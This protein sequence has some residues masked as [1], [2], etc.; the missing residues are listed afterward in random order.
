[1]KI[2]MEEI[3]NQIDKAINRITTE[4]I[5]SRNVDIYITKDGEE[6]VVVVDDNFPKDI[7]RE[8]LNIFWS[9][10]NRKNN[11]LNLEFFDF[12]K[13]ILDDFEERDGRPIEILETSE[14][15]AL[16]DAILKSESIDGIQNRVNEVFAAQPKR[17][18]A[19][20]KYFKYLNKYYYNEEIPEFKES[21]KDDINE[22]LEE[23]RILDDNLVL[24]ERYEFNRLL[25]NKFKKQQQVIASLQSDNME[26]TIKQGAFVM[27][28]PI[29]GV[30]ELNDGDVVIVRK[31][32]TKWNNLGIKRYKEIN[33]ARLL[34]SDNAEYSAIK[35]DGKYHEIIGRVIGVIWA[36]E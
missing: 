25:H 7:K 31:K 18:S 30:T 17:R 16:K 10:R 4:L 29:A 20:L 35:F 11:N 19:F 23:C 36:E 22:L 28:Y 12:H 26:P 24:P 27:A 1:M 6:S 32:K 21:V 34:T 3:K 8:D 14:H 33:G 9:H 13:I 5:D 15:K 2:N